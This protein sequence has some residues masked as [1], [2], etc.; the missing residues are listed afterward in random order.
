[1]MLHMTPKRMILV[2][3]LALFFLW[4]FL[5]SATDQVHMER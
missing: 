2:V 5:T 1:M 3:N 4:W